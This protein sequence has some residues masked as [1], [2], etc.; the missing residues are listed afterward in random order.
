MKRL[1]KILFYFLTVSIVFTSSGFSSICN[2]ET[3][4][5]KHEMSQMDCCCKPVLESKSCCS[6]GE[7]NKEAKEDKA[8]HICPGKFSTAKKENNSLIVKSIV[9]DSKLD[10]EEVEIINSEE[11]ISFE[12]IPKFLKFLQLK[13][14][15]GNSGKDIIISINQLKIPFPVLV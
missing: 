9:I 3:L 12:K 14:F 15:T 6:G 5:K 4:M 7:M 10:F 2:C 1:R 11:T 13:N 8:K